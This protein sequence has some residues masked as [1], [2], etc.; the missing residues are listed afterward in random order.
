M[1]K[2]DDDANERIR[3]VL[4]QIAPFEEKKMFGGVCFMV[5]G[6]MTCGMAKGDLMLRLGNEGAS[7]ALAEKH[8]RPMDFTGRPLKSMV[9]V[10]PE[11]FESD[12]ALAAWLTRAADYA[13]TPEASAKKRKKA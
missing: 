4:K 10:Q 7:A 3:R 12:D 11:G 1:A 5:N 2:A 6:N 13:Q 8:V 9:F